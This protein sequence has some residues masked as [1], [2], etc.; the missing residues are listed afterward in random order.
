MAYVGT[1]RAYTVSSS[2]QET[3]DPLAIHMQPDSAPSRD[4]EGHVYG[5]Q[6]EVEI[7]RSALSSSIP[8][9]SNP[10]RIE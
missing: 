3:F 1:V 4:I 10:S 5:Y 9:F 2:D 6:H 8:I 7:L